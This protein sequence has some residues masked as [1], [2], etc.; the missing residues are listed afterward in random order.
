MLNGFRQYF[1]SKAQ[2]TPH[3]SGLAEL[4]RLEKGHFLIALP[5][6]HSTAWDFLSGADGL[7]HVSPEMIVSAGR[8]DAMSKTT[9]EAIMIMPIPRRWF[10]RPQL[11]AKGVNRAI[12]EFLP[13]GEGW[14]LPP[15]YVW[16]YFSKWDE[17]Q[18][19]VLEPGQFYKNQNYHGHD[20]LYRKW[21]EAYQKQ[22]PVVLDRPTPRVVAPYSPHGAATFH[23]YNPVE[24]TP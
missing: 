9:K 2:H 19:K 22:T 4:T 23:G 14:K 7:R 11:E 16:G 12:G 1:E 13:L 5:V 24:F 17:D 20:G 3:G 21:K 6:E 8:I 18:E 15:N 10:S